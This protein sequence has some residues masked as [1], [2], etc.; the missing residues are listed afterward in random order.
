MGLAN[1]SLI[2]KSNGEL[3]TWGYNNSGQ[4][5]DNTIASKSS[6]VLV[7]CSHNFAS[8]EKPIGTCVWGS[9]KVQIDE[10][11]SRYFKENISGSG[12]VILEMPSE[13][14]DRILLSPGGYFEFETWCFGIGQCEIDRD[15]YVSGLGNVTIKYK[16]GD[17]QANCEADSWNL[18][19]EPFS[20][21]GWIKIRIE[22]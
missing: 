8:I 11:N 15:K 3:W 6:P 14:G 20:C 10:A 21:T 16:N 1:H 13:P 22:G 9:Q 18:Y 17:T 12:F 5:G 2:L 4:L 19:I 7:V